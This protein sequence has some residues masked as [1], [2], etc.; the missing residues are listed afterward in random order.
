VSGGSFWCPSTGQVPGRARQRVPPQVAAELD[1]AEEGMLGSKGRCRWGKPLARQGAFGNPARLRVRCGRLI[2]P[3]SR[4]SRWG[5]GGSDSLGTERASCEGISGKRCTSQHGRPAFPAHRGES[6]ARESQ[7]VLKI[8]GGCGRQLQARSRATAL[9]MRRWRSGCDSTTGGEAC[10][11]SFG[12]YGCPS[13]RQVGRR[14][15]ARERVPRTAGADGDR[16]VAFC[17]NCDACGTRAARAHSGQNGPV[18]LA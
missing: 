17:G 14:G 15:A 12:G 16:C 18:E 8:A 5:R 4:S 6:Y 11:T 9:V 1:D 2:R 10:S 7:E 13:R 3:P